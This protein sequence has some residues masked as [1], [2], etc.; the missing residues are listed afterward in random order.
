[1]VLS[2]VLVARVK[3]VMEKLGFDAQVR[4]RWDRGTIGGLFTFFGAP[5]TFLEII[6]SLKNLRG[7]FTRPRFRPFF[8]IPSKHLS[9][10]P[11]KNHFQKNFFAVWVL[12]IST[13]TSTT[14]S[15]DG[16]PRRTPA[17]EPGAVAATHRVGCARP[18]GFP[19]RFGRAL[20][21]ALKR[22]DLPTDFV[23]WSA[24]N[25]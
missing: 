18:T 12:W 10:H 16:Q 24:L 14:Q 9:N 25:P 5:N 19:V 8:S 20:K 1:M 4:F 2:S 7:K 15:S 21:I 17:H 6:A 3:V 22:S 13:F 11:P 23:T